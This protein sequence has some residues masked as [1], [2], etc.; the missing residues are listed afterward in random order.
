MLETKKISS[1]Q[2]IYTEVA[3]I[4]NSKLTL[5]EYHTLY[6]SFNAREIELKE[7]LNTKK[8]L[9]LKHY[10]ANLGGYPASRDKKADLINKIH[11]GLKSYFHI[12]RMF[13]WSHGDDMKAKRE[14]FITG[15]TQEDLNKFYEERKQSAD[16]NEKALTNPE[17]LAEFNT[18]IREHGIKEL[19]DEQLTAFDILRADIALKQQAAEAKRKA[20]VE[21]VEINAEFSLHQTKHSKT[22]E[23]IFTVLMNARID[24]PTFNQLKIK[25]KQFSGYYSRF[26]RPNSNPPIYRGFNFDSK[27][28]AMLF[29]GLKES[30]Q[31][32]A[33]QQEQRKEKVKIKATDRMEERAPRLRESANDSLNQDRKDN[34]HRRAAMA[35]SAEYKATKQI[36]FADKL[37]AIAQALKLDKITYLDN[38]RNGAQIQQLITLTN[39]AYHRHVR[40]AEKDSTPMNALIDVRF[41]KY[42]YPT[43]GLDILESLF[44]KYT[45]V[46]GVKRDSK[47][48][49]QMAKRKAAS[50]KNQLCV[51]AHKDEIQMLK[52]VASRF[53]DNW[54]RE[55]ILEPIRDFERMQKMGLTDIH[56]LRAAIRELAT[57]TKGAGISEEQKQALE[58]KRLERQFIGRKIPGFFPTPPAIIEKMFAMARVFEGETVLEPNGGLGHVAEAIKREYPTNELSVIEFSYDL[59]KVLEKKGF[60]VEHENF[61]STTHKYD[62]I[63]MNPPF[64]NDQDIDHVRHAYKLLKDGGRLV[65]VVC[66]NKE[67]D[68]AKIKEFNEFVDNHGYMEKNESG[69]FKSAFMPTSVNTSLVYLEKPSN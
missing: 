3:S 4:Y 10:S 41:V 8:V 20:I 32:S 35:A 1:L 2:S 13:S 37:E 28:A 26:H 42:P 48:I 66:G 63:F 22:G 23:D 69:A 36:K 50:T 30:D 54:N 15:T 65:S 24:K 45:D 5:N 44:L 68:R 58:L 39:Q 60:N 21:K 59:S 25:A 43:Y 61:L 19:S 52:N 14:E 46:D 40:H 38:V 33:E 64:E 6:A 57:L 34:T 31:C 67:S 62:V 12:G 11:D 29:M 16:Q 9:N 18:F 47:K 49:I 56:I 55:R 17:T 51:F 7:Y 27:E 53:T